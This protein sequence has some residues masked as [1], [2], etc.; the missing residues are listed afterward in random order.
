MSSTSITPTLTLPTN[1]D[2]GAQIE[3][4]KL[5]VSIPAND[6]T[7]VT[8]DNVLPGDEIIIYDASGICSF[9]KT[10][11]ALV[12]AIVGL[13]N[14]V[15]GDVLMFATEG[16]A[17]P[18]VEAWNK[19]LSA[20]G[21]AVGD[22]DIKKTR[23][24]AYCRDPG[25][26]DY[27]KNEGGLIVCMPKSKGAVYATSDYHLLDGAKSNGRKEEFYSAAAKSANLFYP[28][29]VSGGLM[30]RT[31][32]EAGTIHVL[33]FDENFSDNAGAY[34][35]GMMILRK[36][37]PSGASSDEIRSKLLGA[38]PSSSIGG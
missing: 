33:A 35:V 6:E 22:A 28:C 12:K 15:A 14:A 11:M 30:S 25:T 21:N 26:G 4:F 16:A 19:S 5:W 34:N 3:G 31:A 27:A 9:D 20:I 37:R 17:A 13:A 2:S 32:T 7:G 10:N 23:R 18:F 24:D 38:A 36:E 1:L 29:P 8:I